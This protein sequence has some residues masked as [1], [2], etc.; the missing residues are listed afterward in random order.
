MIAPIDNP[1]FGD[2]TPTAIT[3]TYKKK[4]YARENRRHHAFVIQNKV[5]ELYVSRVMA[6]GKLTYSD[7]PL[8][9]AT[10]FKHKSIDHI[11]N[12]MLSLNPNL[13]LEPFLVY[14]DP[15]TKKLCVK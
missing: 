8:S 10:G 9:Q 3:E 2:L 1:M 15:K 14:R 4:W 11:I 6:H 5:N 7:V 13:D 12:E